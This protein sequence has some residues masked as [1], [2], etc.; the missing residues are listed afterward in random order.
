MGMFDYIT[1][2]GRRYQTKDTPSQYLDEY[3]IVNGRLLC[4]EWHHE[5][6]PKE[7]RKYPNEDGLLGM[8]GSITRVVDKH[9][10]DQN[11]HGHIDM[12]PDSGPYEEYRAK[13]T[14]GDLME[15][16]RLADSASDKQ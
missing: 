13:F 5:E 15:F 6:V 12:V 10:V 4:D 8:V 14:D 11:W 2:E 3:R 7:K 9:D 1:H 16:V